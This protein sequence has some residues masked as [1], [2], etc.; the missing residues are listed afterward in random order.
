[1]AEDRR[2]R[3]TRRLLRDGLLALV[4][5]KGYDQITVQDIL[6]RADVGRA[7]FYAHFR[8]KDDLLVSGADDLRESLRQQMSAFVASHGEMPPE[9]FDVTEM[10]FEHAAKH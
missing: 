7:T 9:R 1:M 6:E 5:E 8:D 3:R 10:L 4:L 2:I